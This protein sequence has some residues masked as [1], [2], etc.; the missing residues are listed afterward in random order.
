MAG[1]RKLDSRRRAVFPERFSPGDVFL[2]ESV[3]PDRVV[4]RLVRP[5]EVPLR[6]LVRTGG[7]LMVDAPLARE[8]VRQA[9]AMIETRGEA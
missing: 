1:T 7:R 3:E 4:F 6:K 5:A 8:K 9:C 2:E